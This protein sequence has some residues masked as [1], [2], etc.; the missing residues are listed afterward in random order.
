MSSYFPFS[1]STAPTPAPSDDP[2][3]EITVTPSASAFYAGETFSVI[4]TFRNTRPQ[5]SSSAVSLA[6]GATNHAFDSHGKP[7]T[8]R[9]RNQIGLNI[10]SRPPNAEAGPSHTPRSLNT[11][12]PTAPEPGFPYSPAA[13]PTYRARGWP[14]SPE[15]DE[16]PNV[17]SPDAWKRKEFG[18]LGREGGAHTRR[19]RS[20]ALGK[21]GLSPQ[22]MV[23]ALGGQPSMQWLL[24]MQRNY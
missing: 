21:G 14:T 15:R 19:T 24:S 23:W 1:S 16:I 4:I 12:T 9:R 18:G 3:L 13:N 10:P 20:L 11:S 2:H 22:E 7:D 5:V 8:S 17:R 6:P